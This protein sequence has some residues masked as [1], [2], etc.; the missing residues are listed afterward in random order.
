M[1]DKIMFA[2]LLPSEILK[3]LRARAKAKGLSVSDIA[4]ELIKS[5]LSKGI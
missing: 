2:F 5:A 1:K 3:E 4:R